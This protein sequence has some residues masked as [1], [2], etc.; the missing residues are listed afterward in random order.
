M[1]L[2]WRIRYGVGA[3]LLVLTSGCAGIVFDEAD[4]GRMKEVFLGTTFSVSLPP[5]SEDRSPEMKGTIL[6]F[7]G[8]HQD[9]PTGGDVFEFKAL[10]LGEDQIRV[11]RAS[12]REY[13]LRIKIKSASDEPAVPMHQP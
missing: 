1:N 13:I 9:P 10:G 11:P 3:A 2:W 4:D 7:L 5:P 6:R 8:R 12:G